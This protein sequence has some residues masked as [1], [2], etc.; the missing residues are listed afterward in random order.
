VR[1][2]PTPSTSRSVPITDLPQ[3]SVTRHKPH[4][5]TNP[6][7]RRQESLHLTP[8]LSLG[9]ELR[10]RSTTPNPT[11]GPALRQLLRPQALQWTIEQEYR[12]QGRMARL[13]ASATGPIP[14]VQNTQYVFQPRAGAGNVRGQHQQG[15]EP[16]DQPRW[17][18][19]TNGDDGHCTKPG[20]GADQCGPGVPA[21]QG[22]ATS[23]WS[24]ANGV[25]SRPI[26]QQWK[27]TRA[28]PA[29][30]AI[31]A[32]RFQ[33]RHLRT[34]SCAKKASDLQWQLALFGYNS[35][36]RRLV[37]PVTRSFLPGSA[38]NFSSVNEPPD[39]LVNKTLNDRSMT[40]SFG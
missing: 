24:Y 8:Q 7:P 15:Q 39:R 13:R 25:Q 19:Q 6:A 37:P 3:R 23:N 12:R 10:T 11:Y 40:N 1:A 9:L 26:G 2:R 14:T 5:A 4:A 29:H 20:S 27:S 16:A 17:R 31:N 33:H 22:V 38:I 32:Q 28:R 34:T 18:T 21:W 36:R 35:L 30:I